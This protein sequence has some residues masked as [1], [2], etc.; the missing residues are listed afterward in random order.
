MN[1]IQTVNENT[2]TYRDLSLSALIAEM[3][4]VNGQ[5]LTFDNFRNEILRKDA[6]DYP[7]Y[8]LSMKE[9]DDLCILYYNNATQELCP[10]ESSCRSVIVEKRTLNQL[11]TQYNKILYN[12][13]S[14]N[15]LQNKDWSRV[16]VQKCYEGTQIVVFHYNDKWYVTTRR[17]LDAQKSTWIKNKSYYD[18]FVEAMNGK[19][20]FDDLNKDYCY[21][22]VLVHHKNQNIVSYN[23]VNREYKELYH[24][25]TVEKFTL[26]EVEYNI[27]ANVKYVNEEH[28]DSLNDLLEELK[29]INDLDKMYQKITSEGFVLKYYSGEVHNSDVTILK[30]QTDIYESIMKLKPNNSNI[31]QCFLELYQKDKLNEFMPFFTKYGA[32]TVRRVH[33]SMRTMSK[34]ILDLYHMTRNK[35]NDEVY[36]E[37]SEQYKRCIYKLHG[38]YI[39]AKK[40]EFEEAK[41]A[42]AEISDNV[43]GNIPQRFAKSVNVFNVYN[44]LKDMPSNELRQLYQDRLVLMN[45]DKCTF[46]N[47]ECI[48]TKTQS[49]LMFKNAPTQQ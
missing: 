37:L 23:T 35:K 19:F 1:T 2:T 27:G 48:H 47:K 10:L 21:H 41:E 42:S 22:F 34:E 43:D 18:M 44:Y 6:D 45:S 4:R 49:M 38:L 40:R 14:I 31:H 29:K 15:F 12:Q 16:T 24:I 13:D 5:N 25:L 7:I 3:R 28:Y 26:K 9:D 11:V 8:K 46:I 39:Q 17:C 36:N 32:D 20:T 33:N 30:L